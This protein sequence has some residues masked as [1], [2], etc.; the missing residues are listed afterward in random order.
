MNIELKTI[1][2]SDVYDYMSARGFRRRRNDSP[3]SLRFTKI[4][5]GRMV[6]ALVCLSCEAVESGQSLPW[7]RPGQGHRPPSG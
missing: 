1:K 3:Y 5:N 4:L 2:V 6:T 7:S